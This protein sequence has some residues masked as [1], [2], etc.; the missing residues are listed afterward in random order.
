MWF[1]ILIILI[2]L[3]LF[4]IKSE[5]FSLFNRNLQTLG[6]LDLSCYRCGDKSSFTPNPIRNYG[7]QRYFTRN[8]DGSPI[9]NVNGQIVEAS[10]GPDI[11]KVKSD[12]SMRTQ[13]Y[14]WE[15]GDGPQEFGDLVNF[16]NGKPGGQDYMLTQDD[17][18]PRPSGGIR[19]MNN[20]VSSLGTTSRRSYTS[21]GLA[22]QGNV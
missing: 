8:L 16:N 22:K 2:V 3:Y 4:F 9:Y 21:E 1:V 14:V 20:Y 12:P 7:Y 5:S 19:P 10:F 18:S 6:H 15:Y 11:W 13:Q 17:D